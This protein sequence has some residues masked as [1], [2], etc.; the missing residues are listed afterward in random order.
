M[1]AKTI[2]GVFLG[3]HVHAG[4]LWSGDYYVAALSPFR[5]NCD[6]VK[7]KVKIHRIKEVVTN[8]SGK[9]KFPVAV[10]RENNSLKIKML[11]L[12]T[13]T[14]TCQTSTSTTIAKVATPV[15]VKRQTTTTTMV[16]L[17]VV[18]TDRPPRKRDR[19]PLLSCHA[20][21]RN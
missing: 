7:S 16:H 1:G 12:P 17:A 18:W 13:N 3:Y 9:F 20:A 8:H 6:E 21:T 10:W 2:P 5:A 15:V 11:E 14:P 19:T 4:G